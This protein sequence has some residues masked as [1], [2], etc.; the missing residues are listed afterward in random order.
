MKNKNWLIGGLI[1][2]VAVM[3]VGYAALAQELTIFGTANIDANWNVEIASITETSAIDA[4]TVATDFTA[5][6]ASFE[7][8]LTEPGATASYA[9]VINNTGSL[10]AIVDSIVVTPTTDVP[11]IEYTFSG[12]AVSDPL[13]A[14][15]G[16]HTG[17]LSVTWDAAATA[18]PELITTETVTVTINYV[19]N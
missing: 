7:V 11:D 8:N 18:I 1:V 14:T 9:I 3:A 16:T 17:T 10:D 12:I 2:A 13:L 15:T 19:Q 6:T 5:T 4:T